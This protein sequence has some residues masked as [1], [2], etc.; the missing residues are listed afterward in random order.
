MVVPL[1][2]STVA[3][4]H[5]RNGQPLWTATLDADQE[6]AADEAHVYVTSGSTVHAL[7]LDSGMAVWRADLETPASAPPLAHGGWVIAAA[8]DR[9]RAFRAS[10]GR[11]IWTAETGRVAF[12]P[13]L[14]GDVLVVPVH[15][16][17]VRAL[18]VVTGRERWTQRVGSP[19]VEP[20]AIGGR[21]YVGT[22][23][24]TLVSF[25][26]AT[27]RREWRW[28]M[29]GLLRGRVAVDD[30]HIYLAGMDNILFALDRGNGAIRWRA[31]LTFRPASGPAV[32]GGLV[33]VPAAQVR[34]LPAFAAETGAETGEIRFN[35]LLAVMPV[36]ATEGA[37]RILAAA[38]VGSLAEGFRLMLL[39]P[40][41]V[42]QL[43]MAPLKEPPGELVPLERPAQA[44]PPAETIG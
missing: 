7:R 4:Y 5:V 31:G 18:D 27:G 33:V 30:R 9:V 38:V 11:L 24:K 13:A 6:L 35:A 44:P 37:S 22:A 40:A 12:R 15:D 26:A 43:Q 20:L 3:A 21:V 16:G 39:E 2:T 1:Q 17:T 32:V 28:A 10:D 42:P 14:D 25:H 8:G 19:P 36:F 41:L 23:G 34:S 29:G